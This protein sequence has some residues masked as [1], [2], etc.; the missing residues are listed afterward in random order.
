M[1]LGASHTERNV[2]NRAQAENERRNTQKINLKETNRGMLENRNEEETQK[3]LVVNTEGNQRPVKGKL[4]KTVQLR[5]ATK[6]N[7][8]TEEKKIN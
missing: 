6:A 3:K 4:N 8:P 5:E 7:G 1:R 2:E